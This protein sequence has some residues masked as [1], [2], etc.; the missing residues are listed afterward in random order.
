MLSVSIRVIEHSAATPFSVVDRHLQLDHIVA[1]AAFLLIG[2][3]DFEI[4]CSGRP[5]PARCSFLFTLRLKLHNLLLKDGR[6]V[7]PQ[8]LVTP[9]MRRSA[10][11]A[12]TG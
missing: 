5:E 6:P 10:F 11:P 9:P 4:V 12:V 8:S 7:K 3:E 2:F 1:G